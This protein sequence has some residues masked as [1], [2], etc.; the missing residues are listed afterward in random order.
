MTQ[1]GKDPVQKPDNSY[2]TNHTP[3]RKWYSASH[4]GDSPVVTAADHMSC[5]S[6]PPPTTITLVP[7]GV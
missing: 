3:P 2:L 6:D 5:A 7:C 4:Q 1:R